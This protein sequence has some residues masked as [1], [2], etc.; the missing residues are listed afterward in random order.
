M[1]SNMEIEKKLER[2]DLILRENIYKEKNLEKENI[3]ER[4]EFLCLTIP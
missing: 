1:I 3:L 2:I 4:W